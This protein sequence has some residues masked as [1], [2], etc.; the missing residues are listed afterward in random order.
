[1]MAPQ[2]WYV[3]GPSEATYYVLFMHRAVQY[4]DM[5]RCLYTVMPNSSLAYNMTGGGGFGL[6]TMEELAAAAPSIQARYDAMAAT[7]AYRPVVLEV[8]GVET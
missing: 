5:S 3:V 7:L 4:F 8:F 2:A 1:M 6:F